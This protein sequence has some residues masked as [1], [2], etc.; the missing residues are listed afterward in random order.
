MTEVAEVQCCPGIK[1]GRS[2]DR[3]WPLIRVGDTGIEP[4]TSSV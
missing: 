2:H 4:V 3:N 1:E